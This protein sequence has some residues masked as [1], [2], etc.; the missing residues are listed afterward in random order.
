MHLFRTRGKALNGETFLLLLAGLYQTESRV[1]RKDDN[2]MRGIENDTV[3]ERFPENDVFERASLKLLFLHLHTRSM[4]ALG[5][6]KLV[7]GQR[8]KA[9]VAAA[10]RFGRVLLSFIP[11]VETQGSQMRKKNRTRIVTRLF[12][13]ALFIKPVW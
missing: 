3:E 1:V 4:T 13:R 11:G 12:K 9:S 6:H 5:A 10:L 8:K 7:L 2:G